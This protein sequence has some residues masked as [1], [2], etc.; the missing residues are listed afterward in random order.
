VEEMA[1]SM[2]TA[3]TATTMTTTTTTTTT[4]AAT[5][6]STFF[7][8]LARP[9]SN[10]SCSGGNCEHPKTTDAEQREALFLPR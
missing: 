8:L 9:F 5:A 1:A 3:T 7:F 6:T 2:S 4:T 10:F